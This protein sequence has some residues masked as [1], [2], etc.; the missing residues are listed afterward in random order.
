MNTDTVLQIEARTYTVDALDT[1]LFRDGRPF[2]N[3]PGSFAHTMTSPLPSTFAGALRYQAF[4]EISA[5]A[6]NVDCDELADSVR[7]QVKVRVVLEYHY[8]EC[9]EKKF[10][11]DALYLPCPADLLLFREWTHAQEEATHKMIYVMP[12]C[13]DLSSGGNF[14]NGLTPLAP[15]DSYDRNSAKRPP[16]QILLSMLRSWSKGTSLCEDKMQD[17]ALLESETLFND[18]SYES[19]THVKIDPHTGSSEEGMLYRTVSLNHRFKQKDQNAGS[20]VTK[21]GYAAIVDTPPELLRNSKVLNLGGEKKLSLWNEVSQAKCSLQKV[22]NDLKSEIKSS[23]VN[24]KK[25]R[26]CF[27]TP[28]L[29]SG[30]VVPC[31]KN[32]LL[33][34]GATIESVACSGYTV[35]S[36]YDYKKRGP[37]PAYRGV[38]PGSVYFIK[39]PEDISEEEL[40]AWVDK[41]CC[42]NICDEQF[43]LNRDGFGFAVVGIGWGES[44]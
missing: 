31:E 2:H 29:F 37:K 36:G 25:A 32:P 12:Q 24:V 20:Y 10:S 6:N 30:G 17:N 15:S 8:K 9:T 33:S 44:A 22:F 4:Q 14:P 13:N 42:H 7:E 5:R 28:V 43:D 3:T 40:S 16:S 23:I 34:F 39:F 21:K 11:E 1:L 38:N 27:L 26:I 35:I 41:V 19:R 18:S